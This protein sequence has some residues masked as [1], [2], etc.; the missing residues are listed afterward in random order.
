[1]LKNITISIDKID[2]DD[3]IKDFKV[4]STESFSTYLKE[5]WKVD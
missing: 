3:L 5:V 4:N 1:M 2:S